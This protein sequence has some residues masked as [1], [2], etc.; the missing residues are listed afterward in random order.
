VYDEAVRLPRMHGLTAVSHPLAE[1][2]A[3]FGVPTRVLWG[4]VDAE[5]FRPLPAPAAGGR[6]RIG[7]AGNFRP[8]QGVEVLFAACRSLLAGG[9]DL[10]LN[11]VGDLDASPALGGLL[12]RELGERL[13]AYGPVAYERVPE[14][15]AA[16][17]VLVIPRPDHRAARYGFPS[18]LPEYLA[19]GRAVVAT[20]VGDQGRVI[21]HRRTGLL[22]EPG[23]PASLATALAELADPVLRQRLADAGRKLAE[24]SLTWTVIAARL[25]E[26]LRTLV[27]SRPSTARRPA[28]AGVTR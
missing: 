3:P 19:L 17:D 12:R 20:D 24:S 4:G 26:F 18:K 21:E 9:A 25:V 27:V 14:A 28:A 1:H 7:Y 2:L 13:R 22:V 6:L 11:L 5:R 23:S 10:E 8:Y 15:L 16:A